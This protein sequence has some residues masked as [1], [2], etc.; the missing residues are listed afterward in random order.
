MELK[1]DGKERK[2]WLPRGIVI[3]SRLQ[4]HVVKLKIRRSDWFEGE[5]LPK[6][7]EVSG[8]MKCP[9]IYGNINT[10]IAVVVEA[11]LDA[12]LIQ[13]C[14]AD[15]C[16]CIA[17][18][19]AGKKPDVNVDCLLR[20]MSSI[21]FALDFDEAG[22]KAFQFWKTTYP[23]LRPWPTPSGKSPG[24]ALTSGVDLRKWISIGLQRSKLL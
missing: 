2:L 14:A 21:L 16:C 5:E 22:R 20:N 24:D 19:G 4:D 15:L 23:A 12:M 8:S 17:I 6:Y 9:A 13:Q 11:E 3:P 7:A 1:E 18:G 10:R